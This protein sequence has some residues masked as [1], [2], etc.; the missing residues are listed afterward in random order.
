MFSFLKRKP[1]QVRVRP[2]VG[3]TIDEIAKKMVRYADDLDVNVI[4]EFN[5]ATFIVVPGTSLEEAIQ[6]WHTAW[7]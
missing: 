5:G 7:G 1:Q 4:C 2:G 3:D 6:L